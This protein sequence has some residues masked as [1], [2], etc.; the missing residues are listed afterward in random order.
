[1]YFN[2]SKAQHAARALLVR[3]DHLEKVAI[4]Y[5]RLGG[6]YRLKPLAFGANHRVRESRIVETVEREESLC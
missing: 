4:I 1:M 5:N 6:S 3:N 2:K